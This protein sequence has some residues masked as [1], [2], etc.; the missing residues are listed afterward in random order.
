MKPELS[1]R[2]TKLPEPSSLQ[3]RKILRLL[4][5]TALLIPTP[6]H[7]FLCIMASIASDMMRNKHHPPV[8]PINPYPM[9]PP[10]P[11]HPGGFQ[12]QPGPMPYAIAYIPPGQI[13]GYRGPLPAGYPAQIYPTP[14]P[15]YL[16]YLQGPFPATQDP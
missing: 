3:F 2:N 1:D 4:L 10:S 9:H 12:T 7:A 16:P 5:V 13:Q 8:P 6:S 14:W 11:M 15:G